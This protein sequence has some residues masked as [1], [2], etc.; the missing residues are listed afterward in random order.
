VTGVA[1]SVVC[2]GCGHRPP[3]DE[4]HP[5]RCANAVPGDDVDHV[6]VRELDPAHVVFPDGD[7]P[8]PFARYRELFHWYHLGRRNGM[9]D[10]DLVA[11]VE[12]LDRKVG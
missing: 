7:E 4:P 10:A 11:I 12:D 3:D 8:N 2:A 5:F 6:M 1:T 9:G